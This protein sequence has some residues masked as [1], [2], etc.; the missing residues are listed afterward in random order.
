MKNIAIILAGG[1][2]A[3]F[4]H[5]TPKQ[6]IFLEKRRIIDYSVKIFANNINID[7]II[8]VCHNKWIN[9][10]RKEYKNYKVINGG[11]TRQESVFL[12]LKSCPDSTENVLIHDAAR[13][14]ISNKII[15]K[16]LK[17]L[18]AYEAVNVSLKSSDSV[19]ISKNNM[20]ESIPNRNTVFLSQT[21]QSFRFKTILKAHNKFKDINCTDDVQ[22]VKKNGI[23]CYNFEGDIYNI[24][25][26][27]DRDLEFAKSILLDKQN[28]Y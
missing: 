18:S 8:I 7:D 5:K 19:V 23:K 20:I 15:E 9:K 27:Y 24:K 16:S 1:M 13:P 12:G 3:R 11:L 6:F 22:L 28:A 17:L 25:I 26:T 2:G 21:P 14:F 10:I 4:K